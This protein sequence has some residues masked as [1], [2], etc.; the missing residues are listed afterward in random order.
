LKD[1]DRF[2]GNIFEDLHSHNLQGV[3][4]MGRYLGKHEQKT[5]HLI[6]HH[7]A[8]QKNW[9]KCH[10]NL[11]CIRVFMPELVKISFKSDVQSSLAS[12]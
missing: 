10:F 5:R 8:T 1:D 12:L 6:G 7:V 3:Y 2:H 9:G 4:K 11:S